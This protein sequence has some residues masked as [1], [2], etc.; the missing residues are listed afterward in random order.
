MSAA[1]TAAPSTLPKMTRFLAKCPF[2]VQNLHIESHAV[3][4]A[5]FR[6]RSSSR[7]L[8]FNVKRPPKCRAPA[9]MP[10]PLP[11]RSKPGLFPFV[12]PRPEQCQNARASKSSSP[13]LPATFFVT[14]SA[15]AEIPRSHSRPDGVCPCSS[16]KCSSQEE[17]RALTRTH[18]VATLWGREEMPL[19]GIVTY[20]GVGDSC[21]QR[22][23]SCPQNPS[24]VG[25]P[26][27]S[28]SPTPL[29]E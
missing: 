28:I 12:V 27:S 18:E 8:P 1:D 25:C 11:A 15:K 10:C 7:L 17:D 21:T 24:C 9:T 13:L 19:V 16:G 26:L 22:R 5:L 29:S 2:T 4:I 23:Y 14:S 3:R 20:C 6:Q